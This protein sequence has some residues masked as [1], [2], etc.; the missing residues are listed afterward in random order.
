MKLGKDAPLGPSCVKASAVT[1]TSAVISWL[2]S[3][4]NFQ[5]HYSYSIFMLLNTALYKS[6]LNEF[7][8]ISHQQTLISVQHTVCINSVEV[9]TV[10]PGVYKHTITGLT[11]NTTYKV[12]H[13]TIFVKPLQCSNDVIGSALK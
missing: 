12:S 6:Y 2:P 4:S 9:R 13:L 8:M 11:P 3:N 5:V 10:K 1:A 7:K